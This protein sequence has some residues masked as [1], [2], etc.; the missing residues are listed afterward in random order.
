MN[1]ALALIAA[2]LESA[3]IQEA[4]R[5]GV[6]DDLFKDEA[7]YY[8]RAIKEHV[9]EFHY[10]PSMERFAELCPN[11][12]HVPPKDSVKVLIHALKTQR[13]AASIDNDIDK[14]ANINVSDPWAAKKLFAEMS[15][16]LMIKNQLRK[17]DSNAGFYRDAILAELD[18]AGEGRGLVGLPW[19]WELMNVKT[20]G[21]EP[22]NLIYFYGRQKSKKTWLL[23]YLAVFYAKLGIK[24]LFFTREMTDKQLTRR[25]YGLLAAKEWNTFKRGDLSRP[26]REDLIKHIDTLAERIIFTEDNNG[27]AGFKAKIDEHKPAIVFHD[28]MKAM[29]DDEMM[30]NGRL[31]EKR[32]IDRVI[33]QVTDYAMQQA[34]IPLILCGHANR[35]GERSKG[36]SKTEQA[37]SDH[38]TRRVDLAI[39]IL[40]DDSQNR[41]G[42]V[43]NAARDSEEGYGFTVSGQ[44]CEGFGEF[45]DPNVAWV[46]D[47]EAADHASSKSHGK[48]DIPRGSRSKGGFMNNDFR[49]GHKAR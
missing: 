13:L 24:V 2:V 22:G 43:I 40:K 9:E 29:A 30:S 35:E 17:T 1:Y 47:V 33:D 41:L 15:Q 36:R 12:S 46:D 5:E 7:A 8:W 31:D 28:Y 14:L 6:E 19:P 49:K 34:K 25:L 32:A 26:D 18:R 21:L 11:Y 37:W 39:R 4:V 27:L 45:M 42:I 10:V 3:S 16:E 48:V 20:S 44:L 38:I 23:L